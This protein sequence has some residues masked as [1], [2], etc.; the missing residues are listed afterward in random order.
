M[1]ALSAFYAAA[2]PI[3]NIGADQVEQVIAL[4]EQA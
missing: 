3:L 2:A 4:A 1:A